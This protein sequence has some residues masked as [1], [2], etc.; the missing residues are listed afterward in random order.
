MTVSTCFVVV[1]VVN[2]S[3]IVSEVAAFDSYENAVALV[4]DE[5]MPAGSYEIQKRWYVEPCGIDHT[6]KC[7]AQH[8]T[9]AAPPN[10]HI[11]CILR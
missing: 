9:H 4:E 8:N 3:G 7:C 5:R 6:I 11:G 1:R 10:P 2:G